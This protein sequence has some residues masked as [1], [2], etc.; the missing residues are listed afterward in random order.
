LSVHDLLQRHRSPAELA[1]LSACETTR[2]SRGLREEAIHLTTAFYAAGFRQV[3]GTLWRVSDDVAR[4]IA[5]DVQ[6]AVADP[7]LGTPHAARALNQAV[8][9]VKEMYQ[10]S[11][12]IWSSHVHVGG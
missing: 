4:H 5:V 10:N 8:R 6:T 1:F 9:D 11:Y 12:S 2:T 7:A 3:I